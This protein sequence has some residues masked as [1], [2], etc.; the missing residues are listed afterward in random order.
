VRPGRLPAR[1]GLLA[2]AALLAAACLW[3]GCGPSS[4]V[5]TYSLRGVVVSVDKAN[6]RIFIKHEAIPGYM[7]AMTMPFHPKDPSVLERAR[8]GEHIEATLRVTD[9]KVTLEHVVLSP[10]PPAAGSSAGEAAPKR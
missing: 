1:G 3:I 6:G 9:Q 8:A 4:N 2:A 7:E 5:R 10:G